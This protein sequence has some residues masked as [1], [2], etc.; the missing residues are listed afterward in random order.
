MSAEIIEYYGAGLRCL[1]AMD[2]HV[3]ANMGAELGATTTVFASD[4][5][6]RHFL[7]IEGRGDDWREI[8]ADAGCRY[9]YEDEIDLSKLEPLIAT[10]SSVPA[11]S[12]VSGT[13]RARRFIK[14]IS[15]HRPIRAGAILPSRLRSFAERRSHPRYRSTSIRP[16]GRSWKR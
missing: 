8:T 14:L 5:E 6:T 12:S 2:R 4:E 1:A 10:P 16:R 13:S 9:D 11:T 15:D 3:I 7:E